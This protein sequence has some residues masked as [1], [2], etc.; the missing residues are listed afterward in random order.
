[1]AE[2]EYFCL[3]A[4]SKAGIDIPQIRLSENKRFLIVKNF[5]FKDDQT[6]GFE[7]ILSLQDK[8]RDKKYSGSYEQV[9]K[10][11]YQFT[12]HKK[13]A[14]AQYFKIVAMNYL[15]KNGDAHL[16]NFGL[17]FTKDFSKIWLSPAYDIV[18]TTSYIYKDKPALTIH[19]KK[20]WYGQ[21]ELIE[22][23]TKSCLLNK[24]EASSYY[25]ECQEALRSTITDIE[26]HISKNPDFEQVGT[27]MIESFK[28]SLQDQTIKELPHELTR[29]W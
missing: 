10:V 25:T 23:G 9:A 3:T 29:T 28:I 6:L 2:N 13:E 18:N 5:I 20:L 26:D 27:R 17:L 16:K 21:D 24:K 1:M 12:T 15:L 11:I 14:L 8:N 22:F 19:G 4:C 7:E